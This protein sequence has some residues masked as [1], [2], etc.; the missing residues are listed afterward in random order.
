MTYEFKGWAGYDEKAAD[1]GLKYEA[2]EPKVFE[3]DDVDVKILY[4]GICGSDA[5]VLAGEFGPIEAG[6]VAGH[7]I[8]GEVVRVGAQSGGL[9]VGD[10][11]G[12]G[13]QTDSCLA[14]EF[15]DAHKEQY[16]A[17]PT[18]TFGSPYVRGKSAG[19]M[20]KG[21][22]ATTWRGPAHF[23]IKL[24]AGLDPA[25]A[26]PLFC[27]GVTVYT[28]L[29]RWGA[30][31][32]K[33]VGVLGIGGLGHMAIQIAK[34]MGADVTAISRGSGKEADARKLGASKYIATGADLAADFA[35]H[36]RSL[37]LIISTINPP[38]VDV[39][40]YLA[41]LRPEGA[42]VLVGAVVEPITF[43]S[44]PL[45]TGAVSV[46][47][48]N[49]GSPDEIRE[50]LA[51]VASH[52]EAAPWVQKWAFEDINKALPEFNKGAPRYRFVL[53]NTE[54]GAKL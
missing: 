20:C 22:F 36:A 43:H 14:C 47:G 10:V 27:G 35:P 3:E 49:T 17:T 7:E 52:P 24:P 25:A 15:C 41:L 4:C 32:G 11:V 13:A 53:A 40:A 12:I 50:L 44:F 1:G 42:F 48:S 23:A 34:A 54:N 51:L 30:G 26:A 6:R 19:T 39:A 2:F 18:L 8:V 16:C 38:K 33:R 46:G 5:S 31:P 28:P 45:I 29:K 21:G 9:A 37:D